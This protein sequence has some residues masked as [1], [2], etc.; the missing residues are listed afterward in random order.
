MKERP[1]HNPQDLRTAQRVAAITLTTLLVVGLMV[2]LP[3]RRAPGIQAAPVVPGSGGSARLVRQQ[4]FGM[5]WP[6]TVNSGELRCSDGGEV[7]FTAGGTTYAVN[8]AAQRHKVYVPIR[9]IWVERDNFYL[10][11]KSMQPLIEAG[12]SLCPLPAHLR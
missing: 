2:S 11:G 1:A 5:A 10:P 7:T 6:L 12:L 9:K 8:A 4:H 3:L